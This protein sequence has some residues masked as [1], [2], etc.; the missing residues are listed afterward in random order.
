MKSLRLFK[1]EFSTMCCMHNS[2]FFGIE[3]VNIEVLT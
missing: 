2:T 1:N 3:V